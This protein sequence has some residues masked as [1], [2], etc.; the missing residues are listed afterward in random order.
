MG[1]SG[2]KKRSA[3][4]ADKERRK[5]ATAKR[6]RAKA[7]AKRSKARKGA[8][9]ANNTA[10]VDLRRDVKH[11]AKDEAKEAAEFEAWMDAYHND[12]S[13]TVISGCSCVGEDCCCVVEVTHYADTRALGPGAE[14]TKGTEG[15]GQSLSSGYISLPK[16][17]LCGKVATLPVSPVKAGVHHVVHC[18]T[19]YRDAYIPS[20]FNN[21]KPYFPR[22]VFLGAPCHYKNK[23]G[24]PYKVL[25]ELYHVLDDAGVVVLCQRGCGKVFH[26]QKDYHRHLCEDYQMHVSCYT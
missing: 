7:A 12:D 6:A 3:K 26:T 20:V 16:C 1:R 5:K 25:T 23:Y 21:H 13:G 24:G 17:Y 18:L 8:A 10:P 4:A 2:K 15:T 14:E 19:C 9:L 11:D 22:Y